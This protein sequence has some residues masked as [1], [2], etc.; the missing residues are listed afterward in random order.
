MRLGNAIEAMQGNIL[1]TGSWVMAQIATKFK[2]SKEFWLS[3][4]GITLR[5]DNEVNDFCVTLQY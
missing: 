1:N 4:K 5:M 2:R 3:H